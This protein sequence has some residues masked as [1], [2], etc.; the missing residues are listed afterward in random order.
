MPTHHTDLGASSPGAGGV[1][2]PRADDTHNLTSLVVTY[3]W[4][5]KT[6]LLQAQMDF[7]PYSYLKVPNLLSACHG[8]AETLYSRI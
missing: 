5:S 6:Q 4:K 3:Q 2:S 8:N 7:G 1:L